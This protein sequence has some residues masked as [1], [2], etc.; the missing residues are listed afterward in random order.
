M[1]HNM[2]LTVCPWRITS[3]HLNPQWISLEFAWIIRD[4]H[5]IGSCGRDSRE[6]ELNV[7]GL[8]EVEPGQDRFIPA[9]FS[10]HFEQKCVPCVGF[11]VGVVALKVEGVVAFIGDDYPVPGVEVH[12]PELVLGDAL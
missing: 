11:S 6:W 10:G 4:R 1:Q 12:L 5:I 7:F 8:S 9:C 2:P 3:P